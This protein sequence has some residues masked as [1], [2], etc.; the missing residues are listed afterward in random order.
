MAS[1]VNAQPIRIGLFKELSAPL[2]KVVGQAAI[3]PWIRDTN[4]R[5]R[6][7]KAERVA[8]Y[9]AKFPNGFSNASRAKRVAHEK[10]SGLPKSFFPRAPKDGEHLIRVNVDPNGTPYDKGDV[11][12]DLAIESTAFP[13]LTGDWEIVQ[14]R[15]RF[16]TR[17]D[18]SVSG[19]FR[20]LLVKQAKASD[21]AQCREASVVARKSAMDW[22]MNS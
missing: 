1:A 22:A 15:P 9:G 16:T 11:L 4:K 20:Y 5:R 12:L 8:I 19:W 7:M 21:A 14:A 6:K 10:L 2:L 17:Y 18:G 3:L 13:G